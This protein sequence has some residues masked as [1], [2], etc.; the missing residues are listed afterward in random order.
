[1]E[2]ILMV[3][4]LACSALI[5]GSEVAFFS[6]SPLQRKDLRESADG[7]SQR[8]IKL[9]EEPDLEQGSKTLLATILIANNFINI[10]IVLISTLVA[11][12]VL[13]NNLTP[14]EELVWNI[15]VITFLIV[16]FGEVIPKVFAT[17]HNVLLS[18]VTAMPIAGV[19][20]MVSPLAKVLIYSSKFLEGSA[21]QSSGI[22]ISVDEL[23][24]ALE[25][26]ND[27]ERSN[28]EQ[29]ILEGIVKFG[30]KDAK[31]IMTSRIDMVAFAVE[32][33]FQ[34]LLSH[35]QR[36]GHSRLPIYKNS[37]DEICGILYSKDLLPHLHN[38]E[39][40]WQV[41]VRSPFIVTENK[42]IDDLLK[43]F[44]ERKIH[45]AIVVDEYGGTSGLVTLEDIIEEI[46]GDISDEFD[47]DD[48]QHSKLDEQNYVFEGKTSLI[49]LYRILEIDG[50]PFEAVKGESDTLAG[51]VIEQSGK[52]PLKGEKI[53]FN[54]L[55]F[56]IEAAD[57]RRI[58]RIKITINAFDET[59]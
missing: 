39:F 1:M 33:S 6:L 43:E 30:T 52:I 19:K 35:I 29:K 50:G 46:V 9:L 7:N 59:D 8:V 58:K 32:S 14:V 49:D 23:G 16:L 12:Q 15:G 13:P 34:E 51:F 37:L 57:K 44:Q 42:K 18:K 54:D 27:N 41:L 53:N 21:S 10:T 5:S 47:A 31:Q 4:L 2:V 48:I 28:E 36:A 24:H 20:K 40:A 45:L 3:V 56:T 17:T 55:T 26:T 25:L 11:G 38:D 22:N